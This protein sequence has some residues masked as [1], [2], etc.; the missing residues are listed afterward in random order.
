MNINNQKLEI[1]ENI[2]NIGVGKKFYIRTYG[3]QSNV[4]DSETIS[5]VMRKLKYQ[6]VDDPFLADFIILNTCSIRENAEKKVFGE[7]GYLQKI[8]QR[9]P[10]LILAVCG[11]MVQNPNI[12]KKIQKNSWNVN[13]IFGTNNIHKLPKLIED[14]V[15]TSYPSVSTNINDDYIVEDLPSLRNN[16]YKAFINITFGCSN[17]CTFCIVPYTRGKERSR[18]P[19]EILNEIN[20][21]IKD[22]YSEITLLGQNVNNYGLDLEDMCFTKLLKMVA[23]TK[24]KRIRFTTSNPWNFDFELIN[25]IKN[26]KNVMPYLHLPIQSGDNEIL[27]RMNRGQLIEEYCAIIK[28]LRT[29]IKD[30]AISTDIIVGFPQEKDEAFQKTLDLYDFCKYDNA[31]TFIYSKRDNTPA[32]KWKDDV[33][34]KTKK[35]RLEKLNEMVRYYSKLNNKKWVDRETEVLVECETKNDKNKYM[36]YT[37]QQKLVNITGAKKTDL[38][39]IIKVKIIEAKQFSLN[40]VKID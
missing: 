12:V 5:G 40:G 3:C 19:K 32:A 28:E 27:D 36:G 31:Y 34:L 17:F 13:I 39:K 2:K 24:I 33:S 26:N 25:I 29:K 1:S 18:Q 14:Y 20:Q 15:F 22:G 11:C 9:K 37:P 21:L 4:R 35:A 23:K 10:D 7:I 30:V 16:K 6:N 8:K 38:G